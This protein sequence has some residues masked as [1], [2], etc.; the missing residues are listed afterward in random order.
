MNITFKF[1]P[2]FLITILLLQYLYTFIN[3]Y[4]YYSD[5]Y[6]SN[7]NCPPKKITNKYFYCTENYCPPKN[8]P[9]YC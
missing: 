5:D 2:I 4:E 6:C 1:I 7:E 9:K 8:I 3:K